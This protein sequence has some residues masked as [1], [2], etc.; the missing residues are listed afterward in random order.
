LENKPDPAYNGESKIIRKKIFV[1]NLFEIAQMMLMA[2]ALYFVIDSVVGRVRVQKISMEPTLVPGEILLVNKLE[3]KFGKFNYGDIVTFHYPLDPRIDYVKRII[4]LP[5]DKVV[6]KGGHVW[7]DDR[8]LFE[9]Y[10]SAPP[11]YEGVWDVPADSL[12]VLG[13]N[14]NP[15]ADSHVW[16]FVPFK[17]VIGKAFAVYWPVTK[18]RGL[19]TPDIFASTG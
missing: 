10:I 14:R 8:E 1:R 2:L 6:V 19:K 5:G 9:P 18:I 13:D 12:F 15:S 16:G 4:G 11:E 17:N 7:V 3:Y